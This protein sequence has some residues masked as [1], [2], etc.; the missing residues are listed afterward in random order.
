VIPFG[1]VVLN[2]S[3][4]SAASRQYLKTHPGPHGSNLGLV[5][6]LSF[7]LADEEAFPIMEAA[8]EPI[9]LRPS[10]RFGCPH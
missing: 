10:E 7:G 5:L 6:R 9:K 8:V 1:L 4:T 3:S 2:P